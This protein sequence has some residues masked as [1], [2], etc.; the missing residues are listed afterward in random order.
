MAEKYNETLIA[1][2][3][4]L[5]QEN[6]RKITGVQELS[7]ANGDLLASAKTRRVRELKAL[8]GPLA[9]DWEGNDAPVPEEPEV[10]PE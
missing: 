7:V 8:I 9:R 6:N 4:A 1:E 3:Q 10:A 5:Q 2:L